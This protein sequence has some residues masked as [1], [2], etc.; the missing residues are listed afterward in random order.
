MP[1]I[2]LTDEKQQ[3]QMLVTNLIKAGQAGGTSG[4]KQSISRWEH[5]CPNL[6]R[7]KDRFLDNRPE[8][9]TH[10]IVSRRCQNR[11]SD[12][13]TSLNR[14]QSLEEAPKLPHLIYLSLSQSIWIIR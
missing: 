1:E 14:R 11:T 4:S 5:F 9:V 3:K 10:R 2:I 6:W 13:L 7:S 8:Q 12:S